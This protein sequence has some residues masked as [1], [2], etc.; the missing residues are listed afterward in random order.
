MKWYKATHIKALKTHFLRTSILVRFGLILVCFLLVPFVGR[1]SSGFF[2]SSLLKSSI[3]SDADDENNSCSFWV[4]QKTK[5]ML[6]GITTNERF[7]INYQINFSILKMIRKMADKRQSWRTQICH[8]T[9]NKIQLIFPHRQWR[10][11]TSRRTLRHSQRNYE[12]QHSYQLLHYWSCIYECWLFSD[13]FMPNIIPNSHQK[14]SQLSSC[15]LQY[16]SI[17]LGCWL[18]LHWSW[19]V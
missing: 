10:S 4:F 19:T 14:T 11:S 13:V 9:Y 6:V 7:Q 3:F 12:N 5:E 2:S 8:K 15:Q 16:W 18:S 17:R 1:A